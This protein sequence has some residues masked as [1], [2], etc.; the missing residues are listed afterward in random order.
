MKDIAIT[1]LAAGRVHFQSHTLFNDLNHSTTLKFIASILDADPLADVSLIPGTTVGAPPVA[2][3]RHSRTSTAA[4]LRAISASLRK[5]NQPET[6]GQRRCSEPPER[7]PGERTCVSV[8]T[9]DPAA[10]RTSNDNATHQRQIFV[11]RAPRESEVEALPPSTVHAS[12]LA[13]IELRQWTI[14]NE[15]P[16]RLKLKHPWLY[17]RKNVCQQ[18]ERELMNVLGIDSYR[19]HPGRGTLVLAFD[20]RTLRRD[21]VLTI[22]DRALAKAEIPSELDPLDL[23]FSLAVTSVPL[24]AVAQ[25]FLPVLL[26]VAGAF[27]LLTSIS[28]FKNTAHR[29]VHQRRLGVDILDAIVVT[30][31]MITGQF[32]AG[33]F[34]CL[35]SSFGRALSAKTEDESTR[36]LIQAFGK[37]AQFVTLWKDHQEVE[38]LLDDLHPGDVVVVHAGEAV[39]VDGRITAGQATIDEHALTGD[40]TLS[41][42]TIGDHVFS[43]T[44][45]VSGKA[46]VTVETVGA[47][48]ASAKIAQILKNAAADKLDR[49]DITQPAAPQAVISTCVLSAMGL[50][51]L[52]PQGT[53]AVLNSVLRTDLRRAAPQVVLP[54]ITL[55]ATRG[56]VIRDSHALQRVCDIDTVLFDKTILLGT[57]QPEFVEIINKLR[58]QGIKQIAIIS[59]DDEG[60]SRELADRF[61]V[62]EHFAGVGSEQKAEYIERLQQT[63][64]KVCFVCEGIDD[65]AA[66]QTADVSISLRGVSSIS[67]DSPQIVFMEASL[68]R[69]CE[70]RDIARELDRNVR[71]TRYMIIIPKAVCIL[72]VFTMGLGITAS[73]LTNN[74]AAL[75]LFANSMLPMHRIL[76]ERA[77]KEARLELSLAMSQFL[78]CEEDPVPVPKT[79]NA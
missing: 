39:P 53:V 6:H 26:P 23:D 19:T 41:P 62:D 44:L 49:Q 20:T 15:T 25:F 46:Y 65:A 51:I 56:I 38:I 7:S 22:I 17:R 3:V 52:G 4:F 11:R 72:G 57:E 76:S 27:L 43:G 59:A 8:K 1:C 37:Q 71:R 50:A 16:G 32:F 75:G 2:E 47:E 74:L 35:C 60:P 29:F 36:L 33:S 14:L 68:H 34:L 42:K 9:G 5:R 67:N 66:M 78:R 55:C 30:G 28:T 58:T 79:I 63:G 69:L 45:T 54:F 13:L 40:S 12:R 73:V 21:Q 48:T 61:Q 18:I 64:R 31:C 77:R 70:L 24:A 10:T